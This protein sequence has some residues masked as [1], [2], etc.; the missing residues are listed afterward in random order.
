M[1]AL[2][3][4]LLWLSTAVVVA[5]CGINPQP[6]LPSADGSSNGA[7]A[8]TKSSAGGPNLGSGGSVVLEPGNGGDSSGPEPGLPG[9]AGGGASAG[10]A[11]GGAGAGGEGGDFAASGAAGVGGDALGSGGPR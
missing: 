11:A 2:P 4:R 7:A 10:E 3:R 8:G 6:D 1:N 9:E 5:A